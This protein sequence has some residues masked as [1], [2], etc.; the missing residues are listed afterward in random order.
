MTPGHTPRPQVAGLPRLFTNT[1]PGGPSVLAEAAWV[2]CVGTVE[3][4][5]L[6]SQARSWY[7]GAN[8]P[9]KPRV[10]MPY[11][12]GLS[13]YRRRCDEVAAERYAGFESSA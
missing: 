4:V 9:G 7:V 5:T 3:S 2:K 1:G 8:I 11:V 6:F 10:F 13:T 12:G